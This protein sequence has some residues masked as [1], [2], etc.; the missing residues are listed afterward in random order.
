MRSDRAHEQ[1]S[2]PC[3]PRGD[4]SPT[5]RRPRSGWRSLGVAFALML[6]ALLTPGVASAAVARLEVS[7]HYTGGSGPTGRTVTA[8]EVAEDADTETPQG[9]RLSVQRLAAAFGVPLT[10]LTEI[11]VFS[12][13]KHKKYALGAEKEL[14]SGEASNYSYFELT[15]PVESES[16]IYFKYSEAAG[17]GEL[18]SGIGETLDVTLSVRGSVF[19]IE[20][21]Q[22][23][24][25][26]TRSKNSGRRRRG[27]RSNS[28]TPLQP[29]ARSLKTN[30]SIR[31][32]SGT[33]AA[34]RRTR[35]LQ[36]ST[37]IFP[38]RTGPYRN[39]TSIWK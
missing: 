28:Q 4:L 13:D 21:P 19:K 8:K 33:A 6:T 3:R 2:D 23:T 24:Q 17:V 39:T 38:T 7:I 32:D 22:I 5:G 20:N 14:L 16:D 11:V 34:P 26:G 1:G 35:S 30:T 9:P 29:T 10:Q 27:T 36:T 18:E 12:P 31:G 25:D 15:G 37:P